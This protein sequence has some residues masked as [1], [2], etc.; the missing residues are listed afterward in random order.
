ML[1]TFP[2]L[3]LYMLIFWLRKRSSIVTP[4]KTNITNT[5]MLL[6]KKYERKKEIEKEYLTFI[7]TLQNKEQNDILANKNEQLDQHQAC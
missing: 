5:M 2:I 1:G 3:N 6:K 4:Q 7:V